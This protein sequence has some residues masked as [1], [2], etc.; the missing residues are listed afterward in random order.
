MKNIVW[1][2]DIAKETASLLIASGVY[3]IDFKKDKDD[4]IKLPDGTI[5]PCYC[6]CR[7]VNRSPEHSRIVTN[8]MET[9]SRLKLKRAEI[10]IGLATAGIPVSSLL[11]DRLNLPTSYV[12]SKPKGYGQGKLVECNPKRGLKAL[13]VDDLLYTGAS[14]KKAVKALSD[15]YGIET[16]GIITIVSLSSWECKENEWNFFKEHNITLYSL[17]SYEYLLDEL[18]KSG[19]ITEK[20]HKELDAFYLKPK[21]YVWE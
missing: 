3:S 13:V 20:H 18:L 6:N 14:L 8:F 5:T 12:R 19:K 9:M 16:I 10:V 21:T 15:E 2:E 4:W 11:A 17:T 7:Y 1:N